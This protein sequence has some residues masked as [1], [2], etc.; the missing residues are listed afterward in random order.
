MTIKKQFKDVIDFLEKNKNLKI[1]QI[2]DQVTEMCSG[3]S[4]GGTRAETWIKDADGKCLAICGYADGRWKPVVGKHKVEFSTKTGTGHGFNVDSKAG[5]KAW[6]A[7]NAKA[8][9]VLDEMMTTLK[10]GTVKDVAKHIADHEK[11]ANAIKAEPCV[12]DPVEGFATKEE[13]IKALQAE[14]FKIAA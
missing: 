1:E 4:G 9:K 14:G 12:L 8:K 11:R 6:H 10:S 7:R 3:K 13:C 5:L 2:I